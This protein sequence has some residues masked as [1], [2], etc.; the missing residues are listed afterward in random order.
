[1]ALGGRAGSE[2]GRLCSHSCTAQDSTK[3]RFRVPLCPFPPV[4]ATQVFRGGGTM[5]VPEN[6]L[7]AV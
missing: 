5:S 2:G 3:P 1:M 7:C 6:L 4:P